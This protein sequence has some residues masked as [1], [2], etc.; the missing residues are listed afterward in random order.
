VYHAGK[1][2]PFAASTANDTAASNDGTPLA[3]RASPAAR[4][5]PADLPRLEL[6]ISY[7]EGRRHVPIVELERAA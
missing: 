2:E 6:R 4:A 1:V 7:L 3:P 5:R